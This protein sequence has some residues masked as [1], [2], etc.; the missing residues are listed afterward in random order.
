MMH[1]SK[2]TVFA[3]SG[4]STRIAFGPVKVPTPD[5]HRHLAPLGEPGEPAG[6]LLDHALLPAAQAIDVDLRLGELHPEVLHLLGFGDDLG[7]VQQRLRRNAA[8]V[9]A[10]AAERRVA[11][12][13]HHLLAEV[14][15]AERRGVATRPRAEHHDLGVDVAAGRRRPRSRSAA[16]AGFAQPGRLALERQDHRAL[17]HPVAFLDRDRGDLARG[18]RRDLHRRLVRLELDQ[19]IV[20]RHRVPRLHE[21]RDHRHVLEIPDVGDLHLDRHPSPLQ[22]SRL[23]G[24]P[25]SCASLAQKRAAS[26]PSIAR[27]S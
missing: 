11:L 4:P 18:R 26:A 24:S 14:G 20:L 22:S 21:H 8:D 16:G 5:D 3:P 25:S 13:Q 1:W 10:D 7:G 23:R 6:Q 27:W 9:Q 15:R 12:D 17:R 2:V 19:R